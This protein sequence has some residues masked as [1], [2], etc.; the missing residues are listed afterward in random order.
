MAKLKRHF[1]WPGMATDVKDMVSTCTECQ[2]CNIDKQGKAPLTKTTS[3]KISLHQVALNIVGPLPKTARGYR[4][5]VTMMKQQADF[6]KQYLRC[7]ICMESNGNIFLQLW[8]F[9]KKVSQTEELVL[10]EF[11]SGKQV[12]EQGYS[13]FK[14]T[15][16]HPESNGTLEMWH[17]TL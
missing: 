4:Y 6:R 8:D 10:L 11:Y 3:I 5:I 12:K 2:K 13:I 14:S 9:P 15:P 17:S 7:S 1:Y 16:Y